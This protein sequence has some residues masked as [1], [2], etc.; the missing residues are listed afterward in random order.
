MKQ[1]PFFTNVFVVLALFFLAAC[2]SPI[3]ISTLSPAPTD[4][5]HLSATPV[6]Q[7]QPVSSGPLPVLPLPVREEVTFTITGKVGGTLTA[8]AMD[9]NIVYLGVGPRLL[10]VDI[11]DPAAPRAL[12]QSEVLSGIVGAIAIQS[13]L[14][15][16]GAGNDFYI[17][18]IVDPANPVPVSSLQAFDEPEHVSW[19]EIFLADHIAYTVSYVNYFSSDVWWPSTSEIQN[20]RSLWEHAN[21]PRVLQSRL[22]RMRS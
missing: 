7:E 2:A 20:S 22:A 3:S 6:D 17:Y 14:A 1:H 10:T 15:Y 19:L 9:G 5:P 13:G 11:T 18:N 8:V 4:A 21:F 16:V 12:W